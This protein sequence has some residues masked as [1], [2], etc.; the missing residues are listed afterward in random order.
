MK[1]EY[2]IILGACLT[3][4]ATVRQEI[5]RQTVL[6]VNVNANKIEIKKAVEKLFKV[7]VAKVRVASLRGKRKRVGLKS[8]G[9]TSD[10]KKAYISLKEG[11][12]N[13]LDEL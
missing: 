7:K 8:I 1:N 4:K 12:I 9:K 13:L 3:E 10:W 6:K 2:G 5:D 11:Q